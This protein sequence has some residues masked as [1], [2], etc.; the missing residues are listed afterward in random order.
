MTELTALRGASRE[1][2]TIGSWTE[3]AGPYVSLDDGGIGQSASPAPDLSVSE[4]R[5]ADTTPAI[6]PAQS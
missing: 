4:S 6:R 5:L 2:L 1:E 3:E